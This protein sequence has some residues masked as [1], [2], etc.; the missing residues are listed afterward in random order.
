M[1]KKVNYIALSAGVLM[2]VFSLINYL[3]NEDHVSL[4]IFVFL[5][6]GFILISIKERFNEIKARRINKYAGT[7]FFVAFFIF[8][9]WIAVNKFDL[10]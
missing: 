10:F 7:F 3:M 5:G 6:L 8:I 1:N 9:Y 4:G 2:I